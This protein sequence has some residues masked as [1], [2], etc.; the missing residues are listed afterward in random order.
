MPLNTKCLIIG[1]G[2]IKDS[3]VPDVLNITTGHSVP[4]KAKLTTSMKE[5]RETHAKNNVKVLLVFCEYCEVNKIYFF[6]VY[7]ELCDK[8]SFLFIVCNPRE[9]LV[10]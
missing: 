10:L 9:I 2:D 3:P 6:P 1:Q 7:Y 4:S 8:I 5:T